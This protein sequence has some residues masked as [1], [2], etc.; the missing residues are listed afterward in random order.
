[1]PLNCGAR[2]GRVRNSPYYTAVNGF[3]L[4]RSDTKI[5]RCSFSIVSGHSECLEVTRGDFVFIFSSNMRYSRG[6]KIF[7]LGNPRGPWGVG[8]RRGERKASDLRS[9]LLHTSRAHIEFP[10]AVE[11]TLASLGGG[12]GIT[13]PLGHVAV[14]R[15]RA[16]RPIVYPQGSVVAVKS[17]F[18]IR[19]FNDNFYTHAL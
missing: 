8:P 4:G 5:I 1:M 11:E 6:G 9:P 12:A 19:G 2:G 15:T 10:P 17:R 18:P 7:T 16:M 13:P 3:T 14:L